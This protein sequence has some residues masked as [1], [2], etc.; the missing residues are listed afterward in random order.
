[1][2]LSYIE[3]RGI[4]KRKYNTILF[5]L[6]GTLTDPK[7]GIT[8]SVQ[9]AL[10]HFGIIETN[11]SNL[12]RFIGP[13]LQESFYEFYNFDDKMIEVAIE[14]YREYFATVGIFE[15][16]IYKEIPQLLTELIKCNKKLII[17][18]SKPTVF[19]EKI[20]RHFNINKYFTFVSGSNI[21][22]TRIKK[23][24]VINYALNQF[25]FENFENIIMVGDRKHDI[26]GANK[27]G[28][29]SI[30]V[31]Y[32]YGNRE[33]LEFEK[34]TYIVNTIAELSSILI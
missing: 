20:L 5:D 22:G 19:A 34:P 16:I 33:E 12:E 31:L 18:T 29:D 27:M 21:D 25:K 8:K 3:R 15:N 26:I 30:G 32:G 7:L 28:I 4:V 24:E 23:A 9:Y 6:D 11:L 10:K 14:T 13:P 1:M 2:P 17:A